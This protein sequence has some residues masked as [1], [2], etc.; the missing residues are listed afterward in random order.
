MPETVYKVVR[1]SKRG[2]LYSAIAYHRGIRVKYLEGEEVQAP[3]GRHLLA[4]ADKD[5]ALEFLNRHE[6]QIENP[7]HYSNY[8]LRRKGKFTAEVW[9][10]YMDSLS[11]LAMS[12]LKKAIGCDP[13]TITGGQ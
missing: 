13:V 4:F 2:V 11:G 6:S 7:Y 5:V 10:A 8:L 3:N 12:M 9:D 1:K